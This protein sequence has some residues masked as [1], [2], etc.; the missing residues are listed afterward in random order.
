MKNNRRE[1]LSQL[2]IC[3]IFV[4]FIITYCH[5]IS[6]ADIAIYADKGADDNCIK[7]TMHMFEWMEYTVSAIDADYINKEGL[8]NFRLLCVPGGDMYRYSQD[9]SNT[10]KQNIKNFVREGGSYIGI[11]GGAYFTGER[12]FWQGEQIPMTPLGIFPG[13]TRGPVDSIAPYPHCTM[14]KIN[15]VDTTHPITQSE[16][17]SAWILYCYGPTFLPD[18]GADIAILGEYDITQQPVIVAF[19]YGDGRVFII[20]THPEFEEDSDRDGTDFCEKFDDQ[21]TDWEFMRNA[22]LW[23]LQKK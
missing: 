15:I 22:V 10:G 20:G 3:L 1:I 6:P 14:C 4:L 11:C 7:A 23:C 9:L 16:P 5:G 18:S 21:G 13:T 12:V 19:A 17:D 8:S 2:R